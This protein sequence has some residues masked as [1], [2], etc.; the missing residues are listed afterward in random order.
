MS[1]PG[2]QAVMLMSRGPIA[3]IGEYL[4][5]F[6]DRFWFHDTV[7]KNQNLPSLPH[8]LTLFF[9]ILHFVLIIAQHKQTL[10]LLQLRRGGDHRRPRLC[11]WGLEGRAVYT[12]LQNPVKAPPH[13]QMP[14]LHGTQ[15]KGKIVYMFICELDSKKAKLVLLSYSFLDSPSS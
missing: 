15:K 2:S 10:I 8:A 7:A 1:L 3:A 12:S 13:Q 4:Q 9:Y 14:H 11:P 6:S 5:H